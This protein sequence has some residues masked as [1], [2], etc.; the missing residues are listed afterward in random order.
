MT[1]IMAPIIITYGEEFK[2]ASIL[3]LILIKTPIMIMLTFRVNAKTARVNKEEEREWK[4]QVEIEEAKQKKADRLA[5]RINDEDA[6]TQVS[7]VLPNVIHVAEAPDSVCHF[8]SASEAHSASTYLF[9]QEPFEFK[10]IQ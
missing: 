5:R 9:F 1:V 3:I 4:R 8:L 6:A 10:W 2:I 7:P